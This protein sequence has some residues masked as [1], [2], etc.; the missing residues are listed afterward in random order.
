MIVNLLDNAAK[1]AP[2]GS[3]VLLE[4]QHSR[5]GV[6]I[7][8]QDEGPGLPKDGMERI[9]DPFHRVEQGDRQQAGTGLGLAICRGFVEALGGTITAAN[10]SDRSGAIFTVLFPLASAVEPEDVPE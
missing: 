6:T 7:R 5:D 1:Y 2:A 8:V 10:R 9:F 4:C 3:R